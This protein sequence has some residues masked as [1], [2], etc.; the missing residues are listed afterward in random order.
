M[1]HLRIIKRLIGRK[2]K[3]S[4]LDNRVH[5]FLHVVLTENPAQ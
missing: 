1:V 3:D 5:D 4:K 2:A